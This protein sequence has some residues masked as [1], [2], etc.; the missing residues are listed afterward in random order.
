MPDIGDVIELIVDI[1]ERN[2]RV[3]TQGTIVLKHNNE[4]Y[5]VEFVNETGETLDFFALRPEQ[6]VVIWRAE[7]GQAVPL[8]EQAA[9]IIANLPD[10]AAQEVLD[11]ARF[12]SFRGQKLGLQG[13]SP[14][15]NIP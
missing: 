14:P 7:T 5:E 8:V 3:G 1:P 13:H 6:F 11:F 9:T 15:P 12:L 2:V 4:A 10:D